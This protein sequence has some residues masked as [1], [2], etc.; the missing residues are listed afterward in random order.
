MFLSHRLPASTDTASPGSAGGRDGLIV[1]EAI[2]DASQQLVGYALHQPDAQDSI[3][4]TEPSQWFAALTPA[5][6]ETL[7]RDKTLFLR[8]AHPQIARGDLA[9]LEASDMVLNIPALPPAQL[10]QIPRY[11]P[12][13]E[14]ARRRGFRLAFDYAVLTP[15]YAEWLP[16]A[17]FIQFDLS[18]LKPEAIANFVKV[19]RSRS[20]ATLIATG[21]NSSAQRDAIQALGVTLYRGSCFTLPPP[22]PERVV[23]EGQLA[24]LQLMDMVGQEADSTV[25]ESWLKLHPSLSFELLRFINSAG[26]GFRGEVRSFRHAVDLMG[27]RRLFKWAALLLTRSIG[28]GTAPAVSTAAIVRG[29]LMELLALA[30]AQGH[31]QG[32]DGSAPAGSPQAPA[33]D[34]AFVV[35]VFSLLDALLA[36]DLATAL[37]HISLP[38]EASDALLHRQ[39]PLAAL[40]SLTLACESADTVAAG[41]LCNSLGLEIHQVNAA[42]LQALAWAETLLAS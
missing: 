23:A 15:T 8:Y 30:Q 13:L 2:L 22:F 32:H 41:A 19:A 14:E 35:G 6:Q 16:L 38:A 5:E 3:W 33:S 11:V 39:G 27:M 4:D 24:P 28:P 26:F 12:L 40:L 37:G 31:A 9:Q 17:S 36:T 10:D 1:H 25:I 18:I 34:T 20:H 21:V 42:H 29:R 7:G